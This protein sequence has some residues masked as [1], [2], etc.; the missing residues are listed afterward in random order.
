MRLTRDEARSMILFKQGLVEPFDDPLDAVRAMLAVQTQYAASLPTAVAARTRK[1]ESGWDV[2]ELIPNGRLVKSWSVRHTL[3]VHTREDLALILGCVGEPFGAK[4]SG[5]ISQL[6]N[7]PQAQMEAEILEALKEGPMARR[8]LHE[9]VVSLKHLP[10][11][12]WGFDVKGLAFAQKLCVVGRGAD[13]K[14]ALYEPAVRDVSMGELLSRY[15]QSYGPASMMDFRHWIGLSAKSV[16][17][18]FAEIQDQLVETVI[19]EMP[20]PLFMLKNDSGRDVFEPTHLL[21]K[22]DPLI[23]AHREKSL[24]IRPEVHAWVFRKAGQ[25]EA[26]VLDRGK[27][28]ATWRLAKA[29]KN[30]VICIEGFQDLGARQRQRITRSAEKLA[31][32]LRIELGEI[33]FTTA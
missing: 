28:V 19:D 8:D 21:A 1:P 5:W 32:K 3:H 11:T 4:L 10:W 12:G 22:F 13:Q 18:A 7:V 33:K 2:R 16:S 14:F 27:A 6:S 30:N 29:T 17:M 9:K 20:A 23:L 31:E 26:V 25:V 15:L 24:F